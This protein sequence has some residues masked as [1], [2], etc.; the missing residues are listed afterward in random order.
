[1]YRVLA[2]ALALVS[3]LA[4]AQSDGGALKRIKDSGTI[5]LAYRDHAAPFSFRGTDGKPAGYSVELCSRVA[6]AIRQEL[7]IP[8]LKINWVA[9]TAQTRVKTIAEGK[10]D[11]EC[12]MTTVTMTRQRQVDFSN[13]IFV[14]GGNVLM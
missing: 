10:A 3:G 8:A 7:K 9:V 11:I 12:G 2:L 13:L 5:T 14:D 6:G 1:M 4:W